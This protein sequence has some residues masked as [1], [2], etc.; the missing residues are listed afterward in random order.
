MILPLRLCV[1]KRAVLEVAHYVSV[2]SYGLHG[3]FDPQY[4]GY[5]EIVLTQEMNWRER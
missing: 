5:I 2:C 1:L 3:S 4:W